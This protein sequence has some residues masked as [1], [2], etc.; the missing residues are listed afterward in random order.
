MGRKD[1]I[2]DNISK[3]YRII[4]EYESII[5]NSTRPEEIDRARSIVTDQ[6]SLI[7]EYGEEYL[8]LQRTFRFDIPSDIGEILGGCQGMSRSIKAPKNA[9]ASTEASKTTTVHPTKQSFSSPSLFRQVVALGI[10]AIFVVAGIAA[11]IC[12][13]IGEQEY[14][15]ISFVVFTASG[16]AMARFNEIREFLTSNLLPRTPQ[17]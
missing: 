15:T 10:V 1:D 2:E 4:H 9:T 3:C 8:K 11:F 6:W 14:A 17:R 13:V 7:C 12:F 16:A 5:R